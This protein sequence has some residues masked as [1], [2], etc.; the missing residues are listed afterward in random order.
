MTGDDAK[1]TVVSIHIALATRLPMRSV[2]SVEAEAGAGLVGDRYHGS[3]HRHVTIQSADGL[4]EASSDLGREIDPGTTRRNLTI[5]HGIVPST[6]GDRLRVGTVDLEVVRIAAPCKLLD[7]VV[8]D[9]A[10]IALRRRAGSVCRVL[11]SGLITVGDE[12]ELAL[13]PNGD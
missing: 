5:S 1:P 7:D 4:A 12:V 10:R 13:P 9:G 2:D 6:P 8:G 11:S 3:R